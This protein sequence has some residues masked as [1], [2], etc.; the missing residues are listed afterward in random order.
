MNER[1]ESDYLP[2]L[3][4]KDMVVFPG[5]VAPLF[6]LPPASLLALDAALGRDKRLFLTCQKDASVEDAG[7]DDLYGV[8]T[9]ADILQVLRAPDGS[10]KILAEGTYPARAIEVVQRDNYL[11]AF[12]VLNQVS[13]TETKTLTAHVRTTLRLF[14]IFAELS[15]RIPPDL[16]STI[17]ATRDP[18]RLLYAVAHHSTLKVEE[19]QEILE[20]NSIEEKF[21]LL[22]Q[23]LEAENQILELENQIAGK[24]KD[25]IGKTQRE[26]Y[27]N[28]QLKVIER[29]L[30]VGS[31]EDP[32]LR[33]LATAIEASKMPDEARE[34]AEKELGRLSRMPA[35]SP[36]A[37]VTR[38]YI[39]WLTEVPWTALSDGEI[40]LDSA[41][42]ILDEDHY[43][44]RKIKQRIVEHLAVI[45]LAGHGKGPILCFVGPPGVG[46]TS[47]GR[48]IARCMQRN[49]VRISLGGVR[50][51]AEIRGHRRTYVGAMPGK[52]IQSMKR[53]GTVNP[54]FLLDEIDKMSSDF[55][56]DPASA[57]LEV[58]DP[59]QNRTFNDHYLEVD[60]DLSKVMFLTTA[61]TTEGI[62]YPLLD[63]MEIIRL[64]GYTEDEKLQ[65]ARRHLLPRQ[66]A[67]HG[68]KP[69]QVRLDKVPLLRVITA[70]TREAGVRELDRTLAT[71]CRKIAVEI[72][73]YGS[74]AAA[75]VTPEKLREHLGPEK[76]RDNPRERTSEV[77]TALGLAWTEAGG[78][79]LP[80]EATRMTGKGNLLLTGKLGEVMQESGK[81]ALSWVR[82]HAGELSIDPEF[83][84]TTDIHIHVPEGA[85]PKDGPSAGITMATA[86]ASALS[87][88]P[89][90][91]DI[92]MTGE[93][94]L[95]GRVL[96]IGGLKEKAMAAHRRRI[97]DIIIPREN[98][99]DIE[100]ISPEVRRSLRF[101]PVERLD[102]V[103]ALALIRP[104][105]VGTRRPAGGK[106]ARPRSQAR[107]AQA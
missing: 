65:I 90:R 89:V 36:E 104:G 58:L 2:V 30:G 6:V 98:L 12:V 20:S 37:V 24:V 67:M 49:F 53:A 71:I 75:R 91:Q 72:V 27:L 97:H 94:T 93:V 19:K 80:V 64:P 96:K 13:G 63:R 1:F 47:L 29:E 101:H 8:G 23:Y 95:R 99:D 102:E 34:K 32:D 39:E 70:Y 77:G 11:H 69:G 68:L 84:A 15:E 83:A 17:R 54:V 66:R 55:R 26:Y 62:P 56:G 100:E 18:V 61:N 38:T 82:A 21:I 57:L 86:L 10:V 31:D 74:P 87:G 107:A 59:E 85:I 50:D 4:L 76:Y 60:Y 3:P 35:M 73:E 81:T 46:K 79:L 9:V 88:L 51:E 106:T 33:E 22:N 7:P 42:R 105:R 52:I 43:G 103:L 44:L 28:E 41:R 45:K 48:S 40:D 14:E 78:E 25:Q 5:A 92:A 16:Y